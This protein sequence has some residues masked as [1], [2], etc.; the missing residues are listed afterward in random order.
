MA[1]PY[2]PSYEA[3]EAAATTIKDPKTL[4]ILMDYLVK[5]D[6]GKTE[7]LLK[8]NRLPYFPY[9]PT[10]SDDAYEGVMDGISAFLEKKGYRPEIYKA[11]IV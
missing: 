1:S 3:G 6:K 7:K 2:Q 10:S 5:G 9:D 8:D 11:R 4:Q